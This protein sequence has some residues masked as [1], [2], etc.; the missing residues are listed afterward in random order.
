MTTRAGKCR[1]SVRIARL[2]IDDS[3]T[4]FGHTGP[5]ANVPYR[6]TSSYSAAKK[7]ST[8]P[9]SMSNATSA[10]FLGGGRN[11]T[12]RSPLPPRRP[13]F[14]VT[15][16]HLL[17]PIE[18]PGQCRLRLLRGVGRH[19]ERERLPMTHQWRQDLVPVQT[20]VVDAG[21]GNLHAPAQEP[22]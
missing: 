6:H 3:W 11:K 14:L 1:M 20:N 19:S 22:W 10:N 15:F 16:G 7:W 4:A 2:R 12:S 13:A 21:F 17:E 5:D 9:R 18:M 8:S